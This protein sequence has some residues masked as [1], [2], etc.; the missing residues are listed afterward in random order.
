MPRGRRARP[1]RR[2]QR[3]EVDE[4]AGDLGGHARLAVGVQRER[5]DRAD[6][7]QRERRPSASGV[8]APVGGAPPSSATGST[9]RAEAPI[10]TAVTATASRPGSS[11]VWATMYI[12]HSA[13]ATSTSASPP[14]D[15]RRRRPR[16][17]RRPPARWR[18]PPTPAA[19]RPRGP[20]RRAQRHERGDRADDQRGVADTGALD[21]EVLQQ[22]HAAEADGAPRGDVGVS[23]SRRPA[24]DEREHRGGGAEAHDGQPRG[25]EPAEGQLGQ[26]DAEA[27]DDAADGEG[28]QALRRSRSCPAVSDRPSRIAV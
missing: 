24:G 21:A 22:D 20:R 8:A 7:D 14:S 13:A 26:R 23:A 25:V 28:E 2:R 11:R 9:A 1:A 18:S 3:L 19:R 17:G 5:D 10:C 15:A 12:A 27:P 4:G 16:P 6:G